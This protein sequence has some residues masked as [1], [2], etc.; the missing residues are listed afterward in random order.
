MN[1]H[2]IT[3]RNAADLDGFRRA[4]RWLACEELAPQHVV[5]SLDE[6][7]GL[8]GEDALRDAPPVSLPRG[9]ARLI[10]LGVCHSDPERYALL[11]QL[12]W[13][14]LNGER[15][16]LEVAS[17]P[18]VH[19]IDAMARAVRRDLH[20]MYAFVRFRRMK[21]EHL[22][23]F[24]AWYEPEHFV[25]EAAA[26]FFIDRFRSLD[27]TI[28]TP[29][30]SMRWD[31]REL[32]FGP[33]G[34]REDA[35]AEDGFE[36]GW[37]GYYESVFNP[38]RVNPVAMR[39]EMPKKYW[40]NLPETAS[41]PGL[42]Q[43]ASRRVDAMIGQEATMPAKR[44]PERALEAMW[45][46]EPATLEDLNAIIAKAGPLVPGATQAVFGEGPKH[47]D[48]VFVGEQPGDQE[49]LQG[50]PFVGPAGR[51][52]DKAMK[53]AG[54]DRSHAYLTNAVKHF[55]F[56]QRGH[57]RIHSKPTAGEV[58]HYRPWLMKEL[59]LVR[60]KL[61]V[62]LGGTAL[63][64]LTGKSTPISRS[65]GRARFGPYLGYVT[66][67]PSYLLRLPDEVT[68]REAY[69]AFVEDLRRI[70]DLAQADP[71]TGELPLAA[72]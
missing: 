33:P 37:R 40:R 20:K 34:R 11:Y 16:L 59:E 72:E 68:K 3:L 47:A 45:D 9:V 23:R 29:V 35:P 4:V 51:L 52:F 43:T 14:V 24:A 71:D 53:E 70:H 48:I 69:E 30:G 64:A 38:A 17:D 67:H 26:P 56:E 7:P 49:D 36:E 5:W 66:V 54:I 25:L 63:L 15:D 1:L 13:R 19:R 2:R 41:I 32:R 28:L 12:V 46:Q 39:A 27:W 60:P 50:R 21:A 58:K 44:T 42:I 62:A 10:E 8:F 57:R 65:R 61:V 55:K 22:E 6:A 31:R 18:L